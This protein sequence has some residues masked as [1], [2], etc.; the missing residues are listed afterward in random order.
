MGSVC[1]PWAGHAA[2]P[3]MLRNGDCEAIASR[4]PAMRPC[5][6]A[7][8]GRPCGLA[9]QADE[10]APEHVGRLVGSLAFGALSVFGRVRRAALRPLVWRQLRLCAKRLIA[11]R[12]SALNWWRRFLE[13]HPCRGVSQRPYVG[14]SVR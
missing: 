5:P 10:L 7:L 13:D 2:S 8:V 6:F 4:G 1:L 14:S 3:I 12:R 11:S 9:L